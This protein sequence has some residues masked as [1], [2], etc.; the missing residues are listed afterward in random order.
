MVVPLNLTMTSPFWRLALA[1]GPS[2][3][4]SSRI[5]AAGQARCPGLGICTPR[6]PYRTTSPRFSRSTMPRVRWLMG[7]AKPVPSVTPER[8]SMAMTSPIISPSML[9]SGPPLLPG[10]MAAE[11]WIRFP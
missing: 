8:D 7:M 2:G 5:S 10:L 4:S 3:G 6:Y 1:A 11:V 9:N